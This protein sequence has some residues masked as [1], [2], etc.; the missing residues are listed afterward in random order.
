VG[1]I[2]RNSGIQHELKI[3]VVD[4][5]KKTRFKNLIPDLNL[6]GK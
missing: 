4:L 2:L 5:P 6:T 3:K 1:E